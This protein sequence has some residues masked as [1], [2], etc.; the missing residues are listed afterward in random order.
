MFDELVTEAHR[1]RGPAAVELWT[2]VE[3]AACAHRLAAMRT[4]LEAAMTADGSTDRDQWCIDNWT[5]VC[6][7]IGAAQRQTSRSVSATLLVATALR[8]RFPHLDA[9][10]TQ[11]LLSY[12][13]VQLIT[14]RASAVIDPTIWA[15]LDTALSELFTSPGH[16]TSL[17]AAEKAIDTEIWRRDPHAVHRSQ[18][19]A[20][21]RRVDITIDDETGIAQLYAS[22]FAPDGAALTAR[23]DA[24]ADTVC[25]HDPR[26][27]QQRRSQAFGALAHGQDRLACLCQ[28][29][30]C[31]AYLRPPSTGIVIH[32][33]AH[34]DTITGP[35]TQPDVPPDLPPTD[36]PTGGTETDRA[37]SDAESAD[38]PEPAADAPE[39]M[40]DAS[41]GES[42]DAD[43]TDHVEADTDTDTDTDAD[44][45]DTSAEPEPAEPHAPDATDAP[46]A[47]EFTDSDAEDDPDTDVETD[48][49]Q[50]EPE[51]AVES[52]PTPAE[53]RAEV[54]GNAS[55]NGG[56]H[57][58]AMNDADADAEVDAGVDVETDGAPAESEPGTTDTAPD[59]PIP[60]LTPDQECA[61]LDGTP[62]PLYDK[63]LT[64]LT[65]AELFN[66]PPR[67]RHLSSLPTA[68][69]LGGGV[70]PG[71]IARRAATGATISVIVHPGQAPPEPHYRPSHKL[72]EFVRCRDQTCRYPGCT[73]P[74]TTADIDHT[75]PYPYGPTAASNLKCLCREHH[76][77]KTFWNG[78]HDEQLPDGTVI[79]T[80]PDGRTHTTRPGSASMF[81]QLCTPTAPITA[82]PAPP[83]QARGLKMPTRRA[84]RRHERRQRALAEREANRQA[85]E[86]DHTTDTRHANY[87]AAQRDSDPPPF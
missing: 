58:D 80:T 76:L 68:V 29:P 36:D 34:P 86:T 77:L 72:A 35:G 81:P 31:Q 16:P 87:E 66:P 59:A 21:G 26:P 84:T 51:S 52:E 64:Q 15:A 61:G 13:M 42:S 49:A 74:A 6:A 19:R 12:P 79:W 7:H 40:D 33:I 2:R 38:E 70:L 10:F 54:R 3:N 60:F 62:P 23:L 85:L 63:P 44:D 65:W 25:P 14:T 11:G 45:A 30:D 9:L 17:Y 71:A 83:T 47:N 75:I 22:L 73:K 53:P 28:R 24:L 82:H 43:T 55:T 20:Q 37:P 78:W 48:A 27:K 50:A 18:A 8:E 4:M 5:A 1:S 46:T 39:E 67:P 32:L 41:T 57:A 56:D 69:L